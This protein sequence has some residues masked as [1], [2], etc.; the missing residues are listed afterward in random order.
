MRRRAALI[1][2]LAV[3][4]V[5]VAG[6][7]GRRWWDGRTPYGPE[8]LTARATLAFVDHAT[9]AAAL[10][11]VTV[12]PAAAGGLTVLGQV[13]WDRPP[14]AKPGASFRIVVLDKRS[15]LLPGWFAVTSARPDDVSSG[16]DG[17]LEI[18]RK[19]YPWL[20]GAGTPDGGEPSWSAGSVIFVESPDAAPVTFS[21]V[22]PPPDRDTPPQHRVASAPAEVDDLLVGLISVGPRGQV[23]WAQRLLN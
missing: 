6:V 10:K 15:H 20:Q 2:G 8:A 23:Y 12:G 21:T 9:A 22:L 4:L 16:L 7:A 19:R 5:G 14:V 17:S 11:P 18:A 13:S 1:C 3:L